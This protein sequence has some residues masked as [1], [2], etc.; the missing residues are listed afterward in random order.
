MR[1]ARA[2]I[3][4]AREVLVSLAS[5]WECAIKVS[6]GKLRLP[7][8]FEDGVLASGFSPMPIEFA[9]LDLLQALPWHHRDPFDR[10]I[11]A[12]ALRRGATVVTADQALGAYG[13]PIVRL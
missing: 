11:L 6:L 5:A 12:Q 1:P 3:S 2:A 4:S 7:E 10:V 8:R 9:D 13:V